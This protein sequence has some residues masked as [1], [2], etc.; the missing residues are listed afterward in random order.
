MVKFFT[1]N[2]P[3]RLPYKPVDRMLTGRQKQQVKK[4]I[5]AQN[6]ENYLNVSIASAT[7]LVNVEMI[8]DLS[9]VIQGDGNGER[10]NDRITPLSIDASVRLTFF[11]SGAPT[12]NVVYEVRLMCV[13]WVPDTANDNLTDF[14]SQILET[15]DDLQ[16]LVLADDVKRRKFNVLYDRH[17]SIQSDDAPSPV[18]SNLV[19][20]N[21][22]ITLGKKP[23]IFNEGATTG[24]N[25]LYWFMTSNNGT[26]NAIE[27]KAHFRLRYKEQ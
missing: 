8:T 14:S 7:D 25:K 23:V 15:G 12:S 13:R 6:D 27:V 20:I 16:G 1:R 19:V 4:I 11:G 2:Y 9:S 10:T 18:L 26:A 21:K 17:V 24:A 22:H 5:L 3:R